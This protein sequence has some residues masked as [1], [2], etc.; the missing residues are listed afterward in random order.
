MSAAQGRPKG[1]KVLVIHTGPVTADARELLA[2]LARAGAD[3]AQHFMSDDHGPLLDALSEDVL[4]V[5]L[6]FQE[7]PG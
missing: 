5:V 7:P 2:A 3:V 4:P 6:K 1:R